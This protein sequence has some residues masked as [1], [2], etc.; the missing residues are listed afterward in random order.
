MKLSTKLYQDLKKRNLLSKNISEGFKTKN[1]KKSHF[2]LK[3]KVHKDGNPGRTVISS[4][5]CHISKIS[6]YVDYHLQP[7]VKEIP[8]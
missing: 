2:Y 7:I 1:P 8:S 4:V 3:P 6:E 5:N